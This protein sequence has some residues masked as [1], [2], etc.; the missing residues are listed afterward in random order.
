VIY[1]DESIQHSLGYICTAFV[2]CP[3]DPSVSIAEALG[4][5]GLVA[6]FDEYKSGARMASRPELQL[7]RE[8]LASLIRETARIA[9]LVTPASE[10]GNLGEHVVETLAQIVRAN[11]LAV[12]EECFVDTGIVTRAAADAAYV[13]YGLKLIPESDSRHVLGL[14]LADHSAYH[15]S[16]ILKTALEGERKTQRVGLESG[17]ADEFDAELR[18]VLRANLRYA[19]FCES[20][21]WDDNLHDLNY[22]HRVLGYGAFL[23]GAVEER[24]RIAF[25]KD[26][27]EIWLGCIH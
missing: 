20:K 6:Y 13:A 23:R 15:L 10:R 5:A 16:Y 25:L 2:H 17:F 7:L 24:V 26:F 11:S 4:R 8:E 14:Q 9:V 22:M 21:P 3:E 19:L 18:W 27:E 12:D 1:V